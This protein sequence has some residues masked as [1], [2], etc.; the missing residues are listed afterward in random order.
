MSQADPITLLEQRLR[1]LGIEFERFFSGALPTPPEAMRD[2]LRV[3]IRRLRQSKSPS[4]VFT[5]RLNNLEAKFNSFNELHNRR[6]RLANKRVPRPAPAPA[7]TD[8]NGAVVIGQRPDARSAE[9]IYQELYGAESK[10]P[11]FEAFESFLSQQVRR[12]QEKTGCD[13]VSLRVSTDSGK[14]RLRAKPVDTPVSA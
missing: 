5:F 8:S 7:A 13:K 3:Q 11:S 10:R 6:M 9:K 4:L 1:K 14:A 12:I 2:E